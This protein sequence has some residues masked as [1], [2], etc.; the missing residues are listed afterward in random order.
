MNQKK[1]LIFLIFSFFIIFIW[2]AIIPKDMFTWTLEVFPAIIALFVL[3]STYRNFKLSNF[4]YTVIWVHAIILLIGGH[5]TYAE[6][7]LFNWLKDI[8]NLDRNYY[9]RLGHFAQGFT[10]ALIA[11]DVLL[12]K[13]QLKAGKMLAFIVI[14]I[15]LAI[16]AG[17]ELLEFAMAMLTG[18]KADAFLGS[19]GDVWDTQWDMLFALIGAVC[20]LI[21]ACKQTD[22]NH[23][24]D[25]K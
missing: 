18:E 2:S 5:Y 4:I 24:A 9:D 19:Q 7:P 25:N 17:Y 13:T 22:S 1:Y 15:C 8:F 23:A 16:S 12:R 20:G 10:P 11:R 6:M 21:I 3:V 14:S